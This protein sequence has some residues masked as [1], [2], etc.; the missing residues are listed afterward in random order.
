MEGTTD[1]IVKERITFV[2]FTFNEEKRIHWAAQNFLPWGRVLIVDN[3]SEDRTVEIARSLGCDVLLNKNEGWVEEEKTV[4]R[5]KAAVETEWIYWAFADEIADAATIQ[6]ILE[7]IASNRYSIINIA[8]KN[9]Y[10]GTFCY[11][12]FSD[13]MNRIFKKDAIDFTGNTIH[14]FGVVTV[15][16]S[17]ILFLDKKKYYVHHFNSYTAKKYL[18]TIDR[19]TDIEAG[20]MSKTEKTSMATI[21]I[22]SLKILIGN[23]WIR[24]A[25]KAG[26][27]GLFVVMEMI[28][29]RWLVEMKL[30][31]A[32]GSLHIARIEELNDSVRRQIVTAPNQS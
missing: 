13:R 10:Y 9:Y 14:N 22:R 21:L 6:T 25:Y 23:Y 18:S 30:Y 32:Q 1:A 15:P 5:V 4:L 3:Y 17:R 11:D 16:E 12:A 28:Y 31:E 7:G 8:R 24:G 29:Y 27:P 20:R 26:L 19:Y 2:I